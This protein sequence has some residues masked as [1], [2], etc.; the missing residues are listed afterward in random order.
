[1]PRFSSGAGAERRAVVTTVC[2]C[3][4]SRARSRKH[5]AIFV[6]A[7]TAC[8]KDVMSSPVGGVNTGQQYRLP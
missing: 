6:I 5:D 4:S 1:M 8:T 2:A 3:A 7:G